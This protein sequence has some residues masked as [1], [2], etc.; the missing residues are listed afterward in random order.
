MI[1]RC[2]RSASLVTAL[3]ATCALVGSVAAQPAPKGKDAPKA[4]KT[5]ARSLLASGL[6]LFQAKDYL[7][8]LAVFRDAN[9]RFPSTKLLLNIATTLVRLDRKAE[10]ANT[11]QRWLDAADSDPAKRAE[12]SKQLAALD[13]DVGLLVFGITP[14]DAEVQL[15]ASDDWLPVAT[16]P[17]FRV[18]PGAVTVRARREGHDPGEK[19]VRVAAG[20][21]LAVELALA[22]TPIPV[23]PPSAGPGPGL[24]VSAPL[25]PAPRRSRIGALVMA[26]VDIEHE[27]AAGLVGASVDVTRRIAAQAAALIGNA[28]GGYVGASLAILDG[29]VRPLL[30]VGLPVFVSDGPRYALRGA[31]GVELAFNRHLA[32]I[33]EIG[34]EYVLNPEAGLADT[35]F[36]PALGAVG[37]L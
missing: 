2:S 14:A 35:L 27:G 12:V 17:R 36:V 11:Y 33:A 23:A 32:L 22:V 4:D 30:A 34:V 13:R 7:G 15:G 9:E 21:S 19:Q 26:H 8:A 3:L 18:A 20:E 6:K 5:D 28:P 25:L 37:R 29:R 1:R 31:A 24:E 16:T 10:A